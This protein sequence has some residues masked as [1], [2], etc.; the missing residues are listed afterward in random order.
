L[1]EIS[2]LALAA[3]AAAI[4]T[5]AGILAYPAIPAL[6]RTEEDHLANGCAPFATVL[7]LA[8]SEYGESAAFVA[9]TG[10]GI[11]ITLTVNAKTGT[12][13]MWGQHDAGTMC[14]VT[15]G[16]GWEPAPD[17]VKRIAP[18]GMPS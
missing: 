9:T 17:A 5:F 10:N 11:V 3:L 1:C 18:A 15:G 4:P 14:L 13:T 2:G 16:E 7:R 8:M 12:W 6:A